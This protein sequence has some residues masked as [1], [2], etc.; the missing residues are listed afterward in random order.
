MH[1]K[2]KVVINAR[3]LRSAI[4]IGLRLLLEDA[5]SQFGSRLGN[6]GHTLNSLETSPVIQMNHPL[7]ADPL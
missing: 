5:T 7:L 6:N 2:A 1:G 4:I 3:S